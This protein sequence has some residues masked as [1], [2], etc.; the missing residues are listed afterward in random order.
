[1]GSSL[2]YGIP[3]SLEF[4]NSAETPHYPW[5]HSLSVLAL[6][7]PSQTSNG[8]GI[9]PTTHT[10]RFQSSPNLVPTPVNDRPFYPPLPPKNPS[11]T[12]GISVV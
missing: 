12:R 8:L 5:V 2:S 9:D 10:Y 7:M 6:Y 11:H 4:N 3:N 1:M